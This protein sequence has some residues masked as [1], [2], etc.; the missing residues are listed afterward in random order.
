MLLIHTNNAP[1]NIPGHPKKL[2]ELLYLSLS[3]HWIRS[4]QISTKTEVGFPF[5]LQL[6]DFGSVIFF[7]N[8]LD[9]FQLWLGVNGW[10]G[11]TQVQIVHKNTRK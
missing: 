5:M 3:L 7:G 10:Y 9:P 8:T 1:I 11:F 4:N 2:A 6:T